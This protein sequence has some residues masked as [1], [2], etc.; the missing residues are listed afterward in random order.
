MAVAGCSSQASHLNNAP[1]SDASAEVPPADGSTDASARVPASDPFPMLDA[2]P[3]PAAVEH[4]TGLSLP[5]GSINPAQEPSQYLKAS[6]IAVDAQFG[7]SIAVSDTLLVIGAP[8]DNRL[9][10]AVY[11]FMQRDGAWTQQARILSPNPL[12][13]GRFGDSLALSGT[14]LVVGAPGEEHL[15]GHAYVFTQSG[16]NWSLQQQLMTP[17]RLVYFGRSVSISGSNAMVGSYG[18]NAAYVF[19]Q[20]GTV[21]PSGVALE[22][23]EGVSAFGYAVAISGTTAA[24]SA[25]GEKFASSSGAGA[26][27]VYTQ[28]GPNW[29]TPTTITSPKPSASGL[30]G[31]ALALS[32]RSLVIGATDERNGAGAATG[33][34][35][36][37]TE[38]GGTW[39]QQQR[40]TPA[41][42]LV[43]HFGTS[44]AMLGNTVAI[45]APFD[46]S[47]STGVNG[48]PTDDIQPGSGAAYVYVQSAESWA[49][50]VYLKA[51][52]T[53]K[54]ALFGAGVAVTPRRRGDRGIHG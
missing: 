52:N 50:P 2:M 45:G 22:V 4:L 21:W 41:S 15:R 5:T 36:L 24:V 33:A 25:T 54:S 35:Y 16:T 48:N 3:N 49:T 44:V 47:G 18:S 19:T 6:P 31:S 28:A 43:S 40:W 17:P 14:T 46:P 1:S 10:G 37:F 11:V 23:P 51:S 9:M 29:G 20:S 30:F 53:R 26:V 38:A 8:W 32:D 27:Y 13:Q 39:R 42:N 12:I 7:A 34:A